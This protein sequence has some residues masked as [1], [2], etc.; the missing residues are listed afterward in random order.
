MKRYIGIHIM[1]LAKLS[2]EFFKTSG[3]TVYKQTVLLIWGRVWSPL[4]FCWVIQTLEMTHSVVDWTFRYHND[5]SGF[6]LR[7]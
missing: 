3:K 7:Y 4:Y 6:S 2:A 5:S 1:H